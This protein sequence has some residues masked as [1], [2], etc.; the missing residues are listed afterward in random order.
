[1]EIEDTASVELKNGVATYVWK[2]MPENLYQIKAVYSGDG[3]YA[4]ASSLKVSV[5]L[6]KKTQSYFEITP[7]DSKTYGDEPFVISTNGGDGT[8]TVKFENSDSSI[9]SI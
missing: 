4:K 5:E 2:D 8:G 6:N 9:L 7:V 3:N 1:M